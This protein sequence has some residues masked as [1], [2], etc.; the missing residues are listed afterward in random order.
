MQNI[1]TSN[2]T[3]DNVPAE[4][5]P[6]VTSKKRHGCLTAWL[7]I[8]ILFNI[9][10][11][12]YTIVVVSSD[13]E[14]YYAWAMPV[15]IIFGVWSV[16]CAIAIFMWKKWGFYG[17]F[18]GAVAGMITNIVIG[19][20]TYM[21]QPFIALLCLFGVLNIGGDKRGWTQLE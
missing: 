17:F 3:Q 14:Q 16:I 12:I 8:I 5:Q 10:V 9:G 13:P 19:N 1:P 6:P 11:T 15:Q 7:L 2:T 4:S 21:L 20:Y 18:L